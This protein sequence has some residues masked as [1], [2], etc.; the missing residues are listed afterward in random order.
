MPA[1]HDHNPMFENLV[2]YGENSRIHNLL[3]YALY[4]ERK[5]DWMARFTQEHGHPPSEEDIRMFVF[6]ISGEKEISSL[7]DDAEN[8]LAVF[9]QRYL[10]Q[11]RE[12]ISKK[13]E[14]EAINSRSVEAIDMIKEESRRLT[15]SVEA[16]L[17]KSR[18]LGPQIFSSALGAFTYS[19]V[20]IMVYLVSVFFG[21][22]IGPFEDALQP[23]MPAR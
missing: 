22:G 17:G 3:A 19:L 16:A 9:G 11:Y 2:D 1:H 23:L 7:R 14:I 18:R 5:R 15:S 6:M 12:S 8:I 10:G 20:L 13:A 4:K 21:F